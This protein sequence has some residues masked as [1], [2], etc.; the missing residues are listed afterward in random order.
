MCFNASSSLAAWA[1]A[2]SIAFYLWNRNRKYD[3]WNAAFIF[4][5][6]LIQLLEAGIWST[7]KE[8][9]NSLFTGLILLALLA[10]PLVQ[11]YMG[12]KYTGNKTLHFLVAIYIALFIWGIFKFFTSK[13][14]S[15]PGKKGHLIWESSSKGHLLSPFTWLYFVGLFIPLLYMGSYGI[16]LLLIGMITFLYSWMQTKGKE[17]SSL[18]CFTA[19]IYAFVALFSS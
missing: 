13:F 10:Q 17:F 15:Y 11:S 7:D 8:S 9:L 19:V 1:I 6:T 16:P 2:N 4:T 5:F 14:K 18:W 12:F 3:R